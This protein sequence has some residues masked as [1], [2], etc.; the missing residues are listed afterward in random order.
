MPVKPLIFYLIW[1]LTEHLH[2]GGNFRGIL[3]WCVLGWTELQS[4]FEQTHQNHPGWEEVYSR[5]GSSG[6]CSH[7]RPPCLEG[8]KYTRIAN[9]S[10]ALHWHD[11]ESKAYYFTHGP[12]SILCIMLDDCC[13]VIK[14]LKRLRFTNLVQPAGK[15][16][17]LGMRAPRQWWRAD[18]LRLDLPCRLQQQGSL[19]RDLWDCPLSPRSGPVMKSKKL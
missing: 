19:G 16:K 12:L 17:W 14:N 11:F 6:Y 9:G 2:R 5:T 4:W 1:Y 3:T 13:R 15:P 8:H 7:C 10:A 18:W